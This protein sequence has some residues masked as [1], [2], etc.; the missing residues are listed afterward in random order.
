MTLLKVSLIKYTKD[1]APKSVNIVNFV[2]I[3]S[4]ENVQRRCFLKVSL[5]MLFNYDTF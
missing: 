5:L 4:L 3:I 2:K 1:D